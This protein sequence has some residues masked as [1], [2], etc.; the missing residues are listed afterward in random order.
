MNSI[1]IE[2]TSMINWNDIVNVQGCYSTCQN[3]AIIL[4]N[5]L[6]LAI[7]MANLYKIMWTL[8]F[9]YKSLPLI[10]T[11]SRL[12]EVKRR[13]VKIISTLPSRV[14]ACSLQWEVNAAILYANHSTDLQTYTIK[15]T[16]MI[17]RKY[18]WIEY[19]KQVYFKLFIRKI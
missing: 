19:S 9:L 13:L 11:A 1:L 10:H 15:I 18:K 12:A 3:L 5:W 17:F 14:L 7:I 8:Q 2:K 6:Y 16:I 4:S